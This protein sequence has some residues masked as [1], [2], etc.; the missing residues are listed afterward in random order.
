L[1]ACVNVGGLVLLRATSRAQ[2]IAVRRSLGATA[3]DIVRPLAWESTV[4]A[5]AGGAVGLLCA[6]GALHVLVGL[7]PERMP[8][9]D[10][11]RLS[12]APLGLAGAITIVTLLLAGLPPALLAAR[13]G[14]AAPL[15]FD[16]RAGRGGAGRR[17]LRHALVAS[18][19]ALALVMLAG[20]GLLARSLDRLTSVPLGYRPEHLSILTITRR[21]PLTDPNGFQAEFERLYDRV[22]PALR[23]LPEVVSLTPVEA[24]PFFGPQV[25]VAR[26][27]ADARSDAEAAANPFIPFEIGDQDYFRTFGIRILRGRA[28]LESEGGDA[29]PVAIVSRSVAERFWPGQNPLGRQLRIARDT[30]ANAWRTVVGEAEHIRYR[31]VRQATPS[32]FVPWRGFFFQGNFAVRTRDPLPAALPALRKAVRDAD[33]EATLARAQ[34]MDGLLADQLALPRL[35]TLLLAAFGLAALLLAATGLYGVMDAAVRERM[36]ELGIRVALGA[37]PARLRADVLTWAARLAII[38]GAAGLL[39]ALVASRFLRSL[40]Y[41][42]SPQDPVALLGALGLLL[43]VTVAAAYVPAWRATR[44]D[45]VRALR[46]E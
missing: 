11:L 32:I 12:P 3:G 6:V 43:V 8:R 42:I 14:L 1:I 19:V 33:P 34:P 10:V 20:A 2:E 24:P 13:G 26:W 28:F 35:S 30:S 31:D 39:A 40:L 46:A 23:A 36:H 18:Q 25:F 5:V 4:L 37:T 38:G 15:R 9:L 7:A 21:I 29:P 27:A 22:A 16:A 45:P 41:Q 17:R 44:A